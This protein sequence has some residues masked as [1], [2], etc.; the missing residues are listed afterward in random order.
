M[1]C[2]SLG[3]ASEV[4]GQER[5]AGQR[6]ELHDQ[7]TDAGGKLSARNLPGVFRLKE[8][9]VGQRDVSFRTTVIINEGVAGNAV[10]PSQEISYRHEPL[11]VPEQPLKNVLHQLVGIGRVAHPLTGPLG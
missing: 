1:R 6:V 5:L 8:P 3:C 10:Y 2:V 9:D 4:R 7:R 11:P